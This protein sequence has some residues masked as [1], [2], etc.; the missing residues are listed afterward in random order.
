[1]S[2]YIFTEATEVTD[3]YDFQNVSDLWWTWTSIWYWTPWYS[4][5]YWWYI[6]T[7][8]SSSYQW[9]VTPPSSIFWGIL[10][11]MKV[12][13]SR[14][15]STTSSRAS[16]VWLEFPSGSVFIEYGR[17]HSSS[18]WW[19]NVAYWGSD[20][21]MSVQEFTWEI[22]MEVVLESNWHITVNISKND[23]VYTY[24]GWQCAD[25]IKQSWKDGSFDLE[26]AR[27]N[28]I[29]NRIRKIEITTLQ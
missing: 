27:W 22:A 11:K 29:Q 14:P 4:Q 15:Q 17:N 19:L 9:N 21:R 7:S 24:D 28:S 10:T 16:A 20:H 5:Y 2:I 18:G 8:N 23:T 3:T 26:I 1:M 13:F 6:W 25:N 12:Y